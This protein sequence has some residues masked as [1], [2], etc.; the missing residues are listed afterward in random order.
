MVTS[1][2][3]GWKTPFWVS[4]VELLHFYIPFF[5]TEASVGIP[6]KTPSIPAK[7]IQHLKRHG[8]LCTACNKVMLKGHT[9][10]QHSGS[11]KLYCS[12]QC[13]STSKKKICHCCLKYA[14]DI[15]L[16]YSCMS[17]ERFVL[18]YVLSFQRNPGWEY[19]D[20]PG[21]H[22]RD[23]EGVLQSEMPQCFKLQVQRMWDDRSGEQTSPFVLKNILVCSVRNYKCISCCCNRVKDPKLLFLIDS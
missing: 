12:P 4:W 9:A 10:F 6:E 7:S 23:C 8:V 21:R 11:S 13:L 19:Q 15:S 22:V 1:L 18:M 16:I 5:V 14:Y 2:Q 3:T 20:H 17:L